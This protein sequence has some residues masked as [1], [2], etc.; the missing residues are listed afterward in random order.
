M[1][2]EILSN[3]KVSCLSRIDVVLLYLITLFKKITDLAAYVSDIW[4]KNFDTNQLIRQY[5]LLITI[6]LGYYKFEVI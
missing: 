6:K 4:I 1:E 3:D 5:F 2:Y